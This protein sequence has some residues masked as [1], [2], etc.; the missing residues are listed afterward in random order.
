MSAGQGVPNPLCKAGEDEEVVEQLTRVLSTYLCRQEACVCRRGGKG[1]MVD[2]GTN[3][4]PEKAAFDNVLGGELT[5][6]L[7]VEHQV[8]CS[9][10]V[11]GEFT[12]WLT[13]I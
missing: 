12:K 6:A 10:R 4:L 1:K 9:A 2:C 8:F 11:R 13:G 5:S 7:D 3:V